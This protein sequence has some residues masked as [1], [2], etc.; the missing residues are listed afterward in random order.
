MQKL[1]NL[2]FILFSFIGFAQLSKTHYIPPITTSN[3]NLAVAEEQYLYISTPSITPINFKIKQLGTTT[4]DG[5]VTNS[6][7]YVFFIGSGTNTQFIQNK[8]NVANVVSNKGFVIEAESLVY[9]TVRINGGQSNQAGQI[10]SKGLAGLGRIYRIG[11]FLNPPLGGYGTNNIS[12]ASI[13]ATENNT[14]VTFSDI[15]PNVQLLNNAA[16][17]NASF[18]KTL[19]SGES[20]IIAVEGPTTANGNG[21]IGAKISATKDIVVNCG[22]TTGSNGTT[23]QDY[24]IDQLVSLSVETSGSEYIFIKNTGQDIVEVPLLVANEDTQVFL[25]NNNSTTPDYTILAGNYLALNGSNYNSTTKNLYIRTDKKIFAYQCIG[26]NTREDLANQNMFFVPPLSCETPRAIDNIPQINKIG[27]KTFNGRITIAT[28]TGSTLTFTINTVN[29]TLAAL[30][31]LGA[32]VQ[33]PFSVL[34]NSDYET[35]TISGLTGNVSIFSTTQLYVAAYGTTGAATFGG[36]Y[37]G[38]AFKPEIS[39]QTP[40]VTQLGCIPNVQLAVSSQTGFDQ[41]NW[42]Y[43]GSPIGGNT[44]T[45]VPQIGQPGNYYVTATI[46]AC[47]T[48]LDSDI[49]PVSNCPTNSDNDLANDNVDLDYDNDGITNCLESLGDKNLNLATAN[50]SINLGSYSNSIT[51]SIITN[52]I[53]GTSLP[54]TFVGD[55]NG[56]FVTNLSSKND[57]ISCQLTF[58]QPIALEIGYPLVANSINLSN[59]DSKFIL[60]TDT[61]KTITVLNPEDQLLIDTNYDGIYETGITEFSSFEIRF[62]I[63][64]AIPLAAGSGLFAFRAHLVSS[65]E[66]TH[67]NLSET[68]SNNATFSIKATCLPKDS[69]GDGVFDQFDLDADNDGITDNIELSSQN[70]I[71]PSGLDI[72]LNGLDD[73]FDANFVPSNSDNDSIPDF[74]D[75]DSDNDGVFDLIESGSNAIDINNNGIIDGNA[76]FFG[77][78]G[79]ANTLE[80]STNSSALNYLLLDYD[81]DLLFNFVDNDSDGDDCSDLIEAAISATNLTPSPNY[82]ISAPITISLQPIFPPTCLFENATMSIA[83]NATSYQWEISSNMGSS[84]LPINNNATYAGSATSSLQITT[85]IAA[86][87]GYQYRVRLDKSGNSCGKISEVTSLSILAL[88]VINSGLNLLQCDD[89][90]DGISSFNLTQK[91]NFLS[92]NYQNE[93][94]RYFKTQNGA[95]T[96]TNDTSDYIANPTS[97]IATNSIVYVRVENSNGCF[98][99]GQINLIV[100]VTQINIP[101]LKQTFYKCDDALPSDS[102]GFTEFDF[103]QMKQIVE[104][105][106][107]GNNSNYSVKFYE[108]QADVLSELN[109]IITLSNFRNTQTNQQN[110]WVRIDS[111]LDNSCFGIGIIANLVVKPLPYLELIKQEKICLNPPNDPLLLTAGILDGSAPSNYTFIWKKDGV[112]LPFTSETITVNTNG[113]Y[114][115]EVTLNGCSRTRTITVIASDIAKPSFPIL[116]DLVDNNTITVVTITANEVLTATKDFYNFEYSL[117]LPNGPFQNS[118]FFENVSPGFHSIYINDRNGCGIV[119]QDIAVLGAPKFFTPN[120]DGYNDTW[121]L[122]GVDKATNAYS[123]IY[124]YDRFGRLLKQISGLGT[125]WDG[126]LNGQSQPADDYWYVIELQNGRIAKGNFSLKR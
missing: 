103:S 60:K 63:K 40:S 43:N 110:I 29:Y 5:E 18:T 70:Y 4:I 93:T 112:V 1:V 72:N 32:T 7:P 113:V 89:D 39:F 66:F 106:I 123:T 10:T 126:K 44:N 54:G 108:N 118:T 23:N 97:Y 76:T 27:D 109:E 21:L 34:G 90:T 98:I 104:A 75:L 45:L 24:G 61:N 16:N 82:S 17:S 37:S 83:T 78:N 15:K 28:K 111:T 69:D 81:G 48:S 86:M 41:F 99:V 65:L 92:I 49:I 77:T 11:A 50:S 31:T 46:S 100:S 124:I 19:N 84:W 22:S 79:L 9:V 102:D 25:N 62:K 80:N 105:Q 6:N 95:R 2:Y 87:D 38:F 122:V 114:T 119:K 8:E 26:D 57:S 3:N 51:S 94:F 56:N 68:K 117:D 35:Y 85:I 74:Q 125:G 47:G 101:A 71:P 33:G 14:I 96:N 58:T 42:F 107:P 13:L 52:S 36:Y 116:V 88:P 30:S 12:F 20:Y 121:N 64:S 53:L 120:Q 115:V 55:A 91:N 67:I 59:S 73:A